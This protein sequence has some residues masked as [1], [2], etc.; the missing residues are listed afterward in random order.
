MNSLACW[1]NSAAWRE[2]VPSIR[3]PV[4]PLQVRG[5]LRL[6]FTTYNGDAFLAVSPRLKNI[7]YSI[8]IPAYNEGARLGATLEK[9][10]GYVRLQGWDAEVIVVNDGSRDNT[11]ELVREFAA[12]DSV[13]RL[14]ENP[15]NRG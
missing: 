6:V 2:A 5:F 1:W 3:Y 11:A 15:G 8:V 10:L 9:V 4:C 14:V 12:R 7:T 13:V